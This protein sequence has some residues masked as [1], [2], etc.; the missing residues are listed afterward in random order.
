[1]YPF[2]SKIARESGSNFY[3]SFFFLPR[4]KR[5]AILAVYA[6]SRLVDDAVDEAASE[7]KARREIALWRDRLR[8]CYNGAQP[9]SEGDARAHPLLPELADAV[10]RFQ[11]PREYFFDLLTGVEMD[12]QKKRYETF[13]ELETYCYH[14]AGTIG[15][16]CNHLFG[17][18]EDRA[19]S[20]AVLLGKA[21]QLTNIVRDVG[22]DAKIGRIYLPREELRRF[23]VAE[24]DL[25]QGRSGPQFLDLMAFEAARAREYFRKAEG[26]LAV[27]KRRKILP[28]EMMSAFYQSILK[29]IER[30]GFPVL[31][32]KIS[33][34][35]PKK[36]SLVLKALVRS[37]V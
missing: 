28:A 9:L 10:G 3:W 21:F 30:E 13:A 5:N 25:L 37:L 17:Y 19:R 22:K 11:I 24:S 27:E 18:P 8:F 15:L 35:P 29:K 20:Y 23:Q 32:R 14:V 31:E 33:L 4:E 26:E 6:F 2:S 16:L 7:P 36:M 1:M 34:S 12:L